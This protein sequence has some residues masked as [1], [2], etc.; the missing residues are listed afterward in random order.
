MRSWFFVT[1]VCPKQTFE[2][3]Q[4]SSKPPASHPTL[5]SCITS[6]SV[7]EPYFQLLTDQGVFAFSQGSPEY[8]KAFQIYKFFFSI[9]KVLDTPI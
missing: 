7:A 6:F 5:S 1:W 2:E 8:Q 9:G 3:D 4:V